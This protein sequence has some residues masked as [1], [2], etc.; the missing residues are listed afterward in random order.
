MFYAGARREDEAQVA[1]DDG[2]QLVQPSLVL[3]LVR[4]KEQ[5]KTSVSGLRMVRI[6]RLHRYKKNLTEFQMI[7]Q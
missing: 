2:A 7:G 5:L 4:P 3:A 1:L 6:C